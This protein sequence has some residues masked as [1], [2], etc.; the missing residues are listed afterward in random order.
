MNKKIFFLIL[1]LTANNIVKGQGIPSF[2]EFEVYTQDK[3]NKILIIP[4]ENKMYASAIDNELAEFNSLKYNEIKEEIKKGIS[5]QILLAIDNKTPAI[6]M[7]HH[8]D[9]TSEVLNYIYNSIGLKYDKVKTKDTVDLEVKKTVLIKD[10]LQKFVHQTK[11]HHEKVRYERAMIKNGEIH[12]TSH[13]AERFMNVIIQNPNLLKELNNK[14]KTNYYI[15]INEFHIGRSYS[16]KENIYL[17]NRQLSTHYT[18]FNQNG[19]EVDAGVIKVEM[20]SDVL[21]MKKIEREYLS[22]IALELCDFMP[23]ANVEKSTLMKEREDDKNSKRQRKEI[24]GI[25]E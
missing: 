24:H 14:Y 20:P 3:D 21:E 2:D 11:E 22:E 7:V 16:S 10:K 13:T 6:S 23:N 4:F 8:K 5:S 12:S 9:S 1:I 15:F 19:R 25:L 17:K 18:V